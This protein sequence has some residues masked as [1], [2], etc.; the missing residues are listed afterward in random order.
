MSKFVCPKYGIYIDGY[1]CPKCGLEVACE[2]KKNPFSSV[3]TIKTEDT[4]NSDKK[5]L[6][7]GLLFVFLGITVFSVWRFVIYKP[8]EFVTPVVL[9]AKT[10]EKGGDIPLAKFNSNEYTVPIEVDLKEGNFL[11]DDLYQFVPIDIGM[12]VQGFDIASVLRDHGNKDLFESFKKDFDVS[13][14][15]LNT[16]LSA[17]FLVLFPK[18]TINEWGFVSRVNEKGVDFVKERVDKFNE[19][20]KDKGDD[21]KYSKYRVRLVKIVSDD[22]SKKVE[23]DLSAEKVI[24]QINNGDEENGSKDSEPKESTSEVKPVT[25]ISYYLLVSTSDDFLDQMKEN[26]EG[27][28]ENITT[29]LSFVKARSELPSFGQLFIFKR[30][31]KNAWEGFTGLF[32]LEFYYDGLENVL[33]SYDSIGLVFYSSGNKLKI[34]SFGSIKSE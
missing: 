7:F 5:V 10:V 31:D 33:N 6:L 30:G 1:T 19:N 18:S 13:D 20:L 24:E 9:S 14:D 17:G 34:T 3:S 23:D 12:T 29:D 2:V 26:S 8:Q 28:I 27:N 25:N 16:Y 11:L 4:H 22:N 21:Y 15:D 32:T